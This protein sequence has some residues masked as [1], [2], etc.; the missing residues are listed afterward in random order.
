MRELRLLA[1]VAGVVYLDA[2]W[3]ETFTAALTASRQGGAAG[4]GAH[5]GTEPMLILAGAFGAL[6]GAFHS[7]ICPDEGRRIGAGRLRRE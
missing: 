1:G 3:K 7:E 4:F 5:A 6:K 2:F